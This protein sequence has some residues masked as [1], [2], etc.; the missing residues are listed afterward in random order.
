MQQRHQCLD[1][2]GRLQTQ[3]IK[4]VHQVLCHTQTDVTW[5]LDYCNTLL[6]PNLQRTDAFTRLSG[7]VVIIIPEPVVAKEIAVIETSVR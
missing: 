6:H 3:V 1:V 5:L 7:K 4:Y 2:V